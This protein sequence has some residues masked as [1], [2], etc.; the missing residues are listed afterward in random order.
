ME[1]ICIGTSKKRRLHLKGYYEPKLVQSRV[2]LHISLQ[3]SFEKCG[4]AQPSQ[5]MR[6][7]ELESEHLSL[8]AVP[9]MLPNGPS[10][11]LGSGGLVSLTSEGA[12]PLEC[13][14]QRNGGGPTSLR[15]DGR[16]REPPGREA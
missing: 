10:D 6:V 15:I 11:L 1:I 9:Q 8:L 14:F 2:A 7:G 4:E 12:S 5:G 3:K 13:F 16:A